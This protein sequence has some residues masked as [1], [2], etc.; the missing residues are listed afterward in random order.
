MWEDGSTSQ[1]DKGLLSK[2]TNLFGALAGGAHIEKNEYG[3]T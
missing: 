3:E 2:I 1:K